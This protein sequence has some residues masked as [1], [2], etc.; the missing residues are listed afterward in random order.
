MTVTVPEVD[1]LFRA[2]PS[3]I[4]AVVLVALFVISIEGTVELFEVV[5]TFA[6]RGC[7]EFCVAGS[8]TRVELVARVVT[9]LLPVCVEFCAST[10]DATVELADM[11]VAFP[12]VV[13]CVESC[14]TGAVEVSRVEFVAVAFVEDVTE[15]LALVAETLILPVTSEAAC[16]LS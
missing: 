7:V 1:A 10:A 15:R 5:V 11:F 9:V 12:V 4:S 8:D 3:A 2:F 16:A 13:V 14:D 6:S